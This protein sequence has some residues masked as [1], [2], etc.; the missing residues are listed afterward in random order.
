MHARRWQ[1]SSGM[2]DLLR[3]TGTTRTIGA[4]CSRRRT[5]NAPAIGSCPPPPPPPPSAAAPTA[6]APL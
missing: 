3:R 4:P 1:R 6:A 5:L 2:G